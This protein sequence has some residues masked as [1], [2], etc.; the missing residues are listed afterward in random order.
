M[1]FDTQ[2]G[3]ILAALMTRVRAIQVASG[4]H[5]TVAA[6]SVTCDPVNVITVPEPLLPFVLVEISPSQRQFQ[7][8]NLVK[9][10]THV[11]L[12]GRLM[13][14]GISP[15]RKTEAGEAF[16]ADIEKSLTVDITLG[17]LVIDT[18]MQEPDGPMVGL[19][20]NNNVFV[21]VDVM[22]KHIRRYGAP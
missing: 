20:A 6:D 15:T 3:L 16:L 13:A 9:I 10:E 7:P 12:T 8:A 4:Y 22:T 21:V 2:R 18:R 11:L 19:G 14:N 17:G 1:A 5:F